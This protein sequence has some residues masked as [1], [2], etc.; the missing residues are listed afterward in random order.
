[1]R[2]P[3][4]LNLAR[5]ELPQADRVVERA[6]KEHRSR[7]VP[8]EREDRALVHRKHEME[9]ARW[10][11]GRLLVSSLLVKLPTVALTSISAQSRPHS[12]SPTSFPMAARPRQPSASLRTPNEE[13]THVPRHSSNICPPLRARVLAHNILPQHS[14]NIGASL[15][16][17]RHVPNPTRRVASARRQHRA[18]FGVPRARLDFLRKSRCQST[19]A[20]KEGGDE[21]ASCARADG[22]LRRRRTRGR[23]RLSCRSGKEVC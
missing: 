15:S 11:A 4:L 13:Q 19:L 22:R 9:V 6:S 14:A 8:L 10:S 17:R 5:V 20:R 2:R 18:N 3:L 7:V 21:L 1:M 12:P 16:R 23:S